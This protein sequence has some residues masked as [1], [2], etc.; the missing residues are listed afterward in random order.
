MPSPH[1]SHRGSR[2]SSSSTARRRKK[3][4]SAARKLG[5]CLGLASKPPVDRGFFEPDKNEKSIF[6]GSVK[7]YMSMSELWYFFLLDCSYPTLFRLFFMLYVVSIFFLAL[8]TLF[9]TD[10]LSF[11]GYKNERYMWGKVEGGFICD[12]WEGHLRSYG[13]WGSVRRSVA[14]G[15][16]RVE[17]R[18][19]FFAVR[20]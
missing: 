11:S 17:V 20:A 16:V 3:K 1:E 5:E 4:K 14:C 18:V 2:S 8:I 10:Q 12:L 7:N 9:F 15:E 13:V 19:E 6:A